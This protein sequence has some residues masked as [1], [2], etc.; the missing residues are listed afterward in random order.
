[1]EQLKHSILE[2]FKDY[3]FKSG[4]G[5]ENQ[6]AI[7]IYMDIL[8]NAAAYLF[9]NTK[10]FLEHIISGKPSDMNMVHIPIQDSS[11]YIYLLQSIYCKVDWSKGTDYFL[12]VIPNGVSDTRDEE[13]YVPSLGLICKDPE[14]GEYAGIGFTFSPTDQ[15]TGCIMTHMIGLKSRLP[16]TNTVFIKDILPTI[17]QWTIYLKNKLGVYEALHQ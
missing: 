17:E 13:G 12:T 6:L 3:Y 16:I 2:Q 7:T 10:E 5:L 1:M 15:E 14:S 8:K 11:K 4:N 9:D